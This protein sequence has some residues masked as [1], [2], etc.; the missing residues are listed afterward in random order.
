MVK[1][2][3]TFI[4]AALI[5]SCNKDSFET[6]HFFAL[7]TIVDITIPAQESHKLSLINN[8]INTMADNIKRD[9]RNINN[10]LINQ[11]VNVSDDLI[12]IYERALFYNSIDNTYNP[13]AYTVQHLYGF[14]EGPFVIPDE[15]LLK[16]SIQNAGFN[17]LILQNNKFYKQT[18]LKIDF[19]ANAKGY[20]I[21]KTSEYIKSLNIYNFIINIGGDLYV[22]GKKNN[23][24]FNIGIKTPENNV[25]D[26]IQIA[27]NAVAT[28]GNY[29]R[30]FIDNG[31]KYNH[32]FSGINYMPEEKYQSVSVIAKTA[33][34]AD[35]FATLFYLLDID[36]IEK[37]CKLYDM[38]V[39]ILTKDNNTV[40]LC[41][42]NKYE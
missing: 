1:Y 34:S 11:P 40:K 10:A 5:V 6:Y 23:N 16:N 18:N 22:S 7:G 14:P 8:F 33:E 9:E 36:K 35:G 42:W 30:Y 13:A 31:K 25:L 26:V 3:I 39:L 4:I 41:G 32:I 20:I 38:A 29:E 27:D 21:D 12:K 28:S 24:Y 2:F 15:K 17:N 37:Y 19:S